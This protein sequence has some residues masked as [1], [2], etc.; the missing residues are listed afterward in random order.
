ML[1]M[2]QC[3]LNLSL[4]SMFSSS[5]VAAISSCEAQ[6]A[7]LN[8]KASV[9]YQICHPHSGDLQKRLGTVK[10]CFYAGEMFQACQYTCAV[11]SLAA[12]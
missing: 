3:G 5:N 6:P 7:L 2:R 4:R 9:F 11:S 12:Q 8:P 1:Q 10:M